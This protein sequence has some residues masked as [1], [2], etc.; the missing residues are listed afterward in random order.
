MANCTAVHTGTPSVTVVD[1]RGLAVRS[2]QLCRPTI[3]AATDLRL[4]RTQRS[5]AGYLLSQSDPRLGDAGLLNIS[6]VADLRGTVLRQSGSDNGST[7]TLADILGRPLWQRDAMGTVT[8]FSQD[9]LGRSYT[10]SRQDA[11]ATGSQAQV[12]ERHYYGDTAPPQLAPRDLAQTANLRGQTVCIWDSAGQ[13]TVTAV[14][15][16]GLAQSTNRRLLAATD[17]RADWSGDDSQ[18][19]TWQRWEAAL[20]A[21]SYG[22]RVTFDASGQWLT[23][24]NAAGHRRRQAYDVAGLLASQWLTL[25]N[26]PEQVI[27]QSQTYNAAG[28]PLTQLQGNG[29][30]VNCTYE[31]ETQRLIGTS[32]TRLRAAK[33]EVL[34]ALAYT[35]DPV[36]NVLTVTDATQAFTWFRNQQISPVSTFTYDSLYQLISASGREVASHSRQGIALPALITPVPADSSQYTAYTRTYSYDRGGNL[37]QIRH[38]APKTGNQWTS[39]ILV[40]ATANRGVSAALFPNISVEQVDA[41]FDP[42]GRQLQLQP[43][44]LLSW[45]ADGRL[46]QVQSGTSADSPREYYAYAGAQRLLKVSEQRSQATLWQRRAVYLDGLELRSTARAGVVSEALEVVSLASENAEVRALH[47]SSGKPDGIAND[48]IRYSY[49]NP[50]GSIE[51]QLDQQGNVIS[52]EEYYPF[53]GTALWAAS[54]LTEAS[55]KTRRYS[56][57]ERDAS[58]LYYFGYR[59]YQPW[60]ARW[61]SPDPAGTQDGLNLYRMAHNNPLTLQDPTGLMPLFSFLDKN[62]VGSLELN[63]KSVEVRKSPWSNSYQIGK[64][65]RL[66]FQRSIVSERNGIVTFNRSS[67]RE[68]FA[69]LYEKWQQGEVNLIRGISSSHF[70]WNEIVTDGVVR[71]EGDLDQ[72]MA[73]MGGSKTRWLPTAIDD[74]PNRF[75]VAGIAR[76]NQMEPIREAMADEQRAGDVLTGAILKFTAGKDRPLPINFLYDGEIVVQGPVKAPDFIVDS[77]LTGDI[78]APID[79]SSLGSKYDELLPLAAPYLP[80]EVK[81]GDEAYQVYAEL[82]QRYLVRSADSLNKIRMQLARRDAA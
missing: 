3:S 60:S 35:H 66:T 79:V 18:A 21:R 50:L 61:L 56:G 12:R 76:G 71:S 2:V 41:L 28:R 49:G 27:L 22:S 81:P 43:G 63:G 59:Y 9:A 58:G 68:G 36:G 33:P 57:K 42:Q 55:L 64:D 15:L 72:P 38:S 7:W 5:P 14:S 30:T 48:S 62:R 32:I 77:V 11:G 20:D 40:A 51:L 70:S 34:Q 13:Q 19:S 6:Q 52:R 69:A 80:G 29:V 16:T 54:S 47:W 82:A 10:V 65:P 67:D 17:S 53:G 8:T 73:T 24:T 39:T 31:G 78:F 74:A 46:Q 4:T 37:T 25:N 44:Q 23:H 75:M 26:Q 45:D 1:N